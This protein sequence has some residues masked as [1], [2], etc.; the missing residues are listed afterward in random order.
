MPDWDSD[1]L[2]KL[3]PCPGALGVTQAVKSVIAAHAETD[4]LPEVILIGR[5]KETVPMCSDLHS[6][7][8]FIALDHY[9]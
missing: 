5:K 4:I 6:G 1:K 8:V 3:K 2:K 7:Y 9:H